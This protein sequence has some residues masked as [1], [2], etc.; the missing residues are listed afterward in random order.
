MFDFCAVFEGLMGAE[1]GF[2][3]GLLVGL[4]VGESFDGA[5][6]QMSGEVTS[7]DQRDVL[8]GCGVLI[9]C[10]QELSMVRASFH[11]GL[12]DTVKGV[13]TDWLHHLIECL[14]EVIG[15]ASGLL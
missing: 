15:A 10:E 1:S 5:V 14:L 4:E 6:E 12:H 8:N 13:V 7:L 2:F 9:E 11:H 3:E